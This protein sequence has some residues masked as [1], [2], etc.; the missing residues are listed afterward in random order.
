[1]VT[2]NGSNVGKISGMIY[3]FPGSFVV[4]KVT[5]KFLRL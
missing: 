4:Q 3:T 5:T 1:M 2:V